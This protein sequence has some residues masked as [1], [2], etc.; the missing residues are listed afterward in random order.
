MTHAGAVDA[1]KRLLK[2]CFGRPR[3]PRLSF[4]ATADTAA[5][6]CHGAAWYRVDFASKHVEPCLMPGLCLDSCRPSARGRH[7]YQALRLRD[8]CHAD[9]LIM[10]NGMDLIDMM[11]SCYESPEDADEDTT[12]YNLSQS[13]RTL[14]IL[15][16]TLPFALPKAC[17]CGRLPAH[18]CRSVDLL[19]D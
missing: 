9:P 2:S 10:D 16:H 19:S 18:M 13:Q 1:A 3:M 7:A 11:C 17:F 5:S 12:Q 4:K 6:R 8:A 14:P 15:H